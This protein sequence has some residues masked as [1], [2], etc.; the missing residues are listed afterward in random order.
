[1]LCWPINVIHVKVTKN[2]RR[3]E[4]IIRKISVFDGVQKFEY[5]KEI[6]TGGKCGY[7]MTV[8]EDGRESFY[9]AWN[10]LQKIIDGHTTNAKDIPVFNG[11][12]VILKQIG[13]K[14]LESNVQGKIMRI[15]SHI[16]ANGLVG[17]KQ[18]T[19]KFETGWIALNGKEVILAE[20]MIK[21]AALFIQGRRAQEQ[22]FED[23]Q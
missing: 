8:R 18:T 6:D 14:Y 13:I 2:E 23:V 20:I 3:N 21:E 9:N 1:M 16:K 5:V 11:T 7:S 10:D 15:P 4:M 22:L 19:L 17:T 12:T